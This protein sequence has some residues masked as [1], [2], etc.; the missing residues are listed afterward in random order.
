MTLGGKKVT[1][2]NWGDKQ[3]SVTFSTDVDAGTVDVIVTNDNGD[4]SD[5][6]QVT[7]PSPSEVDGL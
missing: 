2:T 7:M 1:V 3:I 4:S 6:E 5:P